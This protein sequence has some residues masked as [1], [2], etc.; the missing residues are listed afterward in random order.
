MLGLAFSTD[1]ALA[2]LALQLQNYLCATG[3]AQLA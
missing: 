3:S 2:S 1:N